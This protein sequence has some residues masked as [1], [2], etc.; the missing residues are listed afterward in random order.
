MEPGSLFAQKYRLERVIGEGAMGT[1]WSAVHVATQRRVA[2][3][4]LRTLVDPSIRARI[5]S[6]ARAAGK[7]AHQNV[8]DLFDAGE[9]DEGGAFLVMPLLVGETL[10]ARLKR[11]HALPHKD[12]LYLAREAAKGLAAA[13]A[14]GVLHRDLTP[15]KI[16]FHEEPFEELPSIKLMDFGVSRIASEDSSM[17]GL[18]PVFL[19]AYM[20]PEQARGEEVDARA[21]L[22][23]Y[24]VVLFEAVSGELPF[25]SANLAELMLAIQRGPTRRLSEL[26]PDVDARIEAAVASCLVREPRARAASAEVVL[27]RLGSAPVAYEKTDV[28]PPPGVT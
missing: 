3:R 23:S 7:I 13:H 15:K 28:G 16:F 4:L 2:I 17:H 20:S 9:T 24:G 5:V 27:E 25:P 6:Q 11:E 10:A 21:D 1:V 22:W 19:P 12:A 26:V 8:I 18:R 14:A